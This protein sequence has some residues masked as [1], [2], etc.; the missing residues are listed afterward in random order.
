MV[1]QRLAVL[2]KDIV[3]GLDVAGIGQPVERNVP[4]E[5]TWKDI[6][7]VVVVVVVVVV[8]S[9]VVASSIVVFVSSFACSNKLYLKILRLSIPGK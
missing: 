4:V 7:V 9:F 3:V 6:I 8:A 1:V 2:P 5:Q